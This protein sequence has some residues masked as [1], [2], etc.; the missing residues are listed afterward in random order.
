M[1]RPN[2]REEALNAVVSIIER[3]GI[4]ALTLDAVAAE[5]GMTRAGLL[6]HFPSREDLLLATHEHLANAWEQGMAS[7]A[8][9]AIS[10]TTPAEKHA[11][12]IKVCARS[13][14]RVELLLMLESTDNPELATFWQRVMDRWA[15]PPTANNYQELDAFIAR[16]AADDLWAHEAL[17]AQKLPQ[18]LRDRVVSRLVAMASPFSEESNQS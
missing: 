2:K 8:G 15:P 11:A 4:T 6:Y 10:E 9:K 17:S 16:L 12:Y 18:E 7:S 5:T 13:A 14:R 1:A 3:E